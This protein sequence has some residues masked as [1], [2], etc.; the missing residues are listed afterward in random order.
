[1]LTCVSPKRMEGADSLN[2]KSTGS[3]ELDLTLGRVARI[4]WL[5]VWRTIASSIA[6]GIV[7]VVLWRLIGGPFGYWTEPNKQL[8]VVTAGEFIAAMLSFFLPLLMLWMA[9]RKKYKGFRIALIS[10][11]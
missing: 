10:D 8:I 2:Q 11:E 9:L 4:Y 5:I 3:N 6:F 1:M 7:F